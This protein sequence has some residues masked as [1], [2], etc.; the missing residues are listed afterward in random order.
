MLEHP[1]VE[2]FE[3]TQTH[4]AR[5]WSSPPRSPSSRSTTSWPG[6]P[7]VLLLS[8]RWKMSA[9]LASTLAGARLSLSLFLLSSALL[10]HILRIYAL[11]FF[12][13][14]LFL[15][16]AL[17]PDL[18]P[19]SVPHSSLTLF[20]K[21]FYLFSPSLKSYDFR[22]HP[23]LI[24]RSSLFSSRD[25]HLAASHAPLP[26]PHP[27]LFPACFTPSTAHANTPPTAWTRPPR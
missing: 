9:A 22:I 10:G 21:P 7:R 5:R 20:A 25:Y 27:T 16:V 4:T 13:L 18:H 11:M 3:L 2:R 6:S 26:R 17:P 24:P 1:P 12:I 23:T 8:S 19:P 14:P 15:H